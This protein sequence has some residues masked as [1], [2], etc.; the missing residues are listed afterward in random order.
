MAWLAWLD[1]RLPST[2]KFFSRSRKPVTADFLPS[3]WL[4]DTE[5]IEQMKRLCVF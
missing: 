3:S 5:R 2:L 1:A 4:Q